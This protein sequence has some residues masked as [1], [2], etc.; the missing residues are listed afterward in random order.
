E[1]EHADRLPVALRIRHPELPPRA[2]LDVAPLLLA[3]EC[4]RAAVELAEPG[5]HC[6][7][8]ASA[9]VAVQLEPVLEQPL[10]VVQRVRPL[11]VARKLDR[12]PDVVV[13]RLL[14]DPVE[15]S[16]KAFELT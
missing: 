12:P 6:T 9:S 2:L 1:L 5:D 8:V 3:D 15:L 11:R 4:D 10:D 7:V 16:L 13:A 14:P